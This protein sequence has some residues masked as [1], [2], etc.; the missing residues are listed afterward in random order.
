MTCPGISHNLVV[1]TVGLI[2]SRA[3]PPG[4]VFL[5]Q[6]LTKFDGR[7]FWDQFKVGFRY[8]HSVAVPK[9]VMNIGGFVWKG[10]FQKSPG[11]PGFQ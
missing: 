7:Y 9:I 8:S 6:I 1:R 2:F 3:D 10:L 5:V 4:S 11:L